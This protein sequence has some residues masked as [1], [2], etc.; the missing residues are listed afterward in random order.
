MTF[1]EILMLVVRLTLPVCNDE[2]PQ[3][4]L[5][6]FANFHGGTITDEFVHGS[7][8]SDDIL[9]GGYKFLG[10]F[11]RVYVD[12]KGFPADEYLGVFVTSDGQYCGVYGVGGD[13]F[14]ASINVE[15]RER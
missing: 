7:P 2:G 3:N 13:C 4:I 15:H 11:H 12:D 8:L 6:L 10:C 9:E 5:D 14:L 1:G